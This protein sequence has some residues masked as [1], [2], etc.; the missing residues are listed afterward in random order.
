ME[1]MNVLVTFPV[2]EEKRRQIEMIAPDAE[3]TYLAGC[4]VG[5]EKTELV[6]EHLENADVILG[7]VPPAMLQ[8]CR[9]LKFLQIDSSGVKPYIEGALP[10]GSILACATGAYGLA[11]SEYMLAGM[12]M[13]QKKMLV[14]MENQKNHQ[15]KKE[16]LIRS[17]SGSTV[18]CVGMGDIGSEFLKRCKALGAYTIGVKRTAGDKQEWLD[19]LYTIEEVDELLPRADV[20][21]LVLPETSKTY[22]M[23][24]EERLGRLRSD[25]IVL[26]VGRGNTVDNVALAHMLEDGRLAGAFLDVCEPE[27]MPEDHPLWDAPNTIITPHITGGFTLQ[28][29]MDNIADI[30]AENFRRFCEGMP[31]VNEVDF[32]EGYAKKC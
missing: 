1:K 21:A 12:L 32:V 11:I 22:H 17:V 7:C 20:L 26:N 29:T 5:D 18:L 30:S 9:R 3:Y 16:G 10:E 13:L 19:E 14:Y 8:H 28:Q 15:W 31:L 23:F 24:D 25:A 4:F 6:P 27:P 2:K